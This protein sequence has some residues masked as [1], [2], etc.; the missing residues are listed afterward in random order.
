[1]LD[2]L[3]SKL[4]AHF[5]GTDILR[6]RVSSIGQS[7][8]VRKRT[9]FAVMRLLAAYFEDYPNWESWGVPTC[10]G[11]VHRLQPCQAG[12]IP[13]TVPWGR[14][15]SGSAT[16]ALRDTSSPAS[17]TFS[18]LDQNRT[19]EL[20]RPFRIFLNQLINQLYLLGVAQAA[21]ADYISNKNIGK[22]KRL[23]PLAEL[24]WMHSDT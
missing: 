1:M 22:L 19:T 17:S 14:S 5:F 24:C 23:I 6:P 10:L 20:H 3:V 8:W 21:H 2:A 18:S 15:R 9:P 7:I 4:V 13:D 12:W 11:W 16:C